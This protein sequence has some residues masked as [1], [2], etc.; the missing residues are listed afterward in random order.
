MEEPLQL[1]AAGSTAGL[2]TERDDGEYRRILDTY[3]TH[4]MKKVY[5]NVNYPRRAVKKSR[6][7]KVELLAHLDKGGELLDITLD[8]SSGYTILDDAARKAVHLAAPFPELPPEVKQEFVAED[9]ES[10]VVM[11]PVTFRLQN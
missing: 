10:Y 11:I 8:N 9:G 7:G 4:V 5:G 6:Q 3:V 2:P 1:P